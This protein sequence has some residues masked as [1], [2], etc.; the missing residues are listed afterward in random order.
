MKRLFFLLSV[1]LP[2]LGAATL[3]IAC[4]SRPQQTVVQEGTVRISSNPDGALVTLLGK[5]IGRTP[6]A[7]PNLPT[8][9]YLF[10][11]EKPGY[12]PVWKHVRVHSGRESVAT[13]QLTP[14]AASVRL[15]SEP[16]GA[17]VEVDGKTVGTT[18]C[19]L[20]G[21]PL[22][23]FSCTFKLMK[24]SDR[25]LTHEVKDERPFALHAEMLNN[26][27][28]LLIAS[29]PD[30]AIRLNDEAHGNTPSAIELEAGEYTLDVI[31]KGYEPYRT[32]IAIERGK[33]LKMEDIVLRELPGV[34]S[35]KAIPANATVTI[36]GLVNNGPMPYVRKGIVPGKY[37]A[38][39]ACPGYD[40]VEATIVVKPDETTQR[41]F[42][43]EANTGTVEIQVDPPGMLVY[44]DNRPVGRAE[45]D[46]KDPYRSKLIRVPGLSAGKHTVSARHKSAVSRGKDSVEVVV[47]KGETTRAPALEFYLPNVVVTVKSPDGSVTEKR[48]QLREQT[49]MVIQLEEA[50]GISREY[51]LK[52]EVVK[53]TPIDVMHE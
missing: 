51:S 41:T 32:Q 38:T 16:E 22:G 50:R 45:A 10:K 8:G 21:I 24:H 13:A 46:P 5:K 28:R 3:P 29:K 20:T 1:S 34:I 37:K 26:Y 48:G 39:I 18:P 49:P 35:L 14:V 25:T 30:A 2:L 17:T 9:T 52:D 7:T 40:P 6:C 36:D 11:V 42:R 15:T 47:A 12:A 33:D 4:D 31:A 53:I 23:N 44:V 43:L 27:G 19:V